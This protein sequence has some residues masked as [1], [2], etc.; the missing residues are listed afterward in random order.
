MRER[1]LVQ[2]RYVHGEVR[3]RD[4]LLWREPVHEWHLRYRRQVRVFRRGGVLRRHEREHGMSKRVVFDERCLQTE[5]RLQCELGLFGEH[6]G[7]FGQRMR[8]MHVERER[9]LHGDDAVL[10][11][12]Q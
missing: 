7:V 8:A 3:Q 9:L 5:Q 6:S 4:D 1:Q 12:R 11:R 10:R 2:W